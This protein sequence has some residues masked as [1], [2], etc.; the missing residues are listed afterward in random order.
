MTSAASE[1][2]PASSICRHSGMD[3]SFGHEEAAADGNCLVIESRFVS[4]ELQNISSDD[5]RKYL[6]RDLTL[7]PGIGNVRAAELK[8]KQIFS[9]ADLKHTRFADAAADISGIIEYGSV[10]EILRLFSELHR[11][12]EPC[13][14][15]LS[16]PLPKFY[17]DIE[18]LG[19]A[20]API[21]LLGCGEMDEQGIKVTQ[22]LI[23]DIEEELPALML[24]AR[25]F[26]K[27]TA[28]VTYNGRCFDVPYLN[29]RL[30]YYGEREVRCGIHFD[31][32]HPTR[33]LFRGELSDCRLETVETAVPSLKRGIDVPGALVP[34]YYQRY[35][36]SR[37]LSVLKPV[38]EHNKLDVANLA[39]L[40]DFEMKQCYG[41]DTRGY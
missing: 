36:Q 31:L 40:L 7:V 11:S 18:T 32:L 30:A 27:D 20:H 17:F 24:A 22:Y 38:I 13:L 28:V 23:R 16:A 9:I 2:V 26:K 8:R 6:L 35:L 25:H 4:P 37:N 3:I 29:S 19:M 21:I 14:L 1:F 5:V 15:G 33:K 34:L 41:V 39:Y 12:S 10:R